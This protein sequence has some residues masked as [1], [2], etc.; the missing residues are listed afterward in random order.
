[1]A[2]GDVRPTEITGC[3]V[4]DR[5]TWVHPT[6]QIPWVASS[7]LR[8]IARVAARRHPAVSGFA[9]LSGPA[10]VQVVPWD[11]SWTSSLNLKYVLKDHSAQAPHSHHSTPASAKAACKL[12]P[13]P[14]LASFARGPPS[15]HL[16]HSACELPQVQRTRGGLEHRS[17]RPLLPAWLEA[18]LAPSSASGPWRRCNPL[19]SQPKRHR[20]GARCHFH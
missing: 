16:A 8:R 20:F 14:E 4:S 18:L 13:R 11:M 12:E 1:M 9:T 6:G 3:S 2:S 17:H 5:R 7:H 19:T 15:R 10:M